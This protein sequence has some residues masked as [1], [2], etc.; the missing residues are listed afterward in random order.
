MNVRPTLEAEAKTDE[1]DGLWFKDA[2]VYQLHVKAFQDSNHDG[3]GDFAGLTERLDYLRDLGVTTLWLLPFYPSPGRDD[4]Y[5]ISDYGD[6]NPQFGNMRDFRR[7]MHEAKRRGLRVITELVVNHT[8]DQHPWFKRAKRSGRATSARNWYVWS[9]NDEKYSG[10]RI[11]FT[12]TEK[13]N[14]TW[15]DEAGA[16]YWHRFFSHQPD[17]NFDNPRVVKAVL[18]VMKRWLDYGVDGFRLDAVPYLCEREGT[19]NENLPETHAVLRRL[20][21]ELDAYAPGK[22]LLAEA[23]QWPEDVQAYFGDGDE[24]HMA[25]HFPL[26]PR[27]YM[28][29]AQED[30]FPITD[31]MRQTPEIPDNCQWAMFLRNHDELT[32]EMVTD[33]ERDYLWSTY[34]ADPRAR[35]NLGIRRRLAPLMDN[36][37]RKIELM[38]SILMSMPGTPII[39]YGD[40]IGMGD[41]IYLGDRNGV[42][43]PM[44]WTPDRNGGFSRADP[45]QLYLPCIMDPVYGFSAVNVEAQTRSLSSLLSWTKRLIAVRKSTKVFGRGTLTF[46][47]PHNRAVLAYVRQLGDEAILCVANISRSA[48]AVELDMRAWE[49]RIPQEMLGRTRFPRIGELPYLV[50]LPPYGFFWFSLQK[51]EP[52]HVPEHV[53]PREITTLVL[54][55]DWSSMLAGFTRRTLEHDV[56]P[57]FLPERR[58]FADKGAR[59]IATVCSTTVPIAHEGHQFLAAIVDVN[60]GVSRYFLPLT[61]RWTRYTD[62]D[63]EPAS[64]L[65]AVRRGPRE[66]VLLDATAERD[67]IAA[68][69]AK[70]HA[71]ETVTE[72]G[73]AIEFRPTTPFT[74][75]PLPA[76]EHVNPITREQSNSSVIVDNKYVVKVLRR[77][78]AGIHPEVEVGRFLADVAHFQNAPQLLGSVELKEGDSRSALAV[79]HAFVENQGDAW[80][81]TAAALDRLIDEHRVLT[82]DTQ[83]ESVEHA[84]MLQRMRQIGKRTAEMHLAF[85]CSDEDPAFR[86]EPIAADDVAHWTHNLAVR[87]QNAF[88]LLERLRHDLTP[89]A[90]QLAQRL[91][92]NREAVLSY[93][94]SGRRAA[95]G[96]LKIRHHGDFHLGQVLIAKDDAYILDFEGE[97]RRSLEE[98]RS[99]APPARDVAGFLRSIDYAASAAIDRSPDLTAEERTNLDHRIRDWARDMREAYWESYRET[100]NG[101]SLLWPADEAE[102]HALLDLFLLEKA[103]YEI[104]YELTNRPSWSHIPLEGTLRILEQREVI[105]S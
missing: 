97:P 88:G 89:H 63:R 10:T 1:D 43:T 21:A 101:D 49:G 20:R 93:I 81:V 4:G 98:R 52:E 58:W 29:I 90:A 56:L 13:S 104:E 33:A 7:F 78:T 39:Y 40:E 102:T 46:I 30:R 55:P 82:A 73:A 2:I 68:M 16:Y 76:I 44:Q 72:N 11:I 60:D 94:E 19:N 103:L 95:Y 45:A 37:R 38:N 32:L 105:G 5:D 83:L 12:D 50:T 47:R 57:G 87:T 6:I 71:G 51:E 36:D 59:S 74:A 64:V 91:L 96:G 84:S 77:I 34:A 80:S 99:K 15:D 41:N 25:Y 53:L 8:S 66:G 54:G 100:L 28:A 86:P 18:Q 17:L 69:M 85:A 26:M 67:F 61:I 22:V 42:R 9:D 24:C 75:E 14:W 62:I 35:I 92:D 70:I 3:V 48:Q 79:V 27:I 31:I 65:A 23:N